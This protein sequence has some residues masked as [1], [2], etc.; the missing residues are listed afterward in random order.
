MKKNVFFAAFVGVLL[1]MQAA[2]FAAS[3]ACISVSAN[4][5]RGSRVSDVRTLQE[6]LVSRNYPGGG[7]WMITGYFGAATE[8]AVRNFQRESGLAVTGAVDSATRD[9]IVRASCGGTTASTPATPWY[10][11][12]FNYVSGWTPSAPTYPSYPTYPTYPL[13]G[14]QTPFL[15]SMSVNTGGPGTVVTIWGRNFDG[16]NNTVYFGTTPIPGVSS[17]GTSITFTVPSYTA[18]GIVQVK[19]GNSHGMS[20]GLTFNMTTQYYYP[21]TPY[22]P[23]QQYGCTYPY[24]SYCTGPTWGGVPTITYLSPSSGAVGDTV[25]VYGSGFSQTGNSVRFGNGIIAGIG[26]ADGRAVTFTVP[27]TISGYGSQSIALTTYNVSVTNAQ[28]HT[29]NS[30]PF[31]VTSLGSMGQPT[32]TNV[33]GPTTLASGTLG[34]WSLTA[35]NPGGGYLSVSVDWG[36]QGTYAASQQAAQAIYNYQQTVSFTHTYYQPGTYTIRFTVTNQSGQTNTTTITVNVTGTQQGAV[37]LSGISPSAARVGTQVVLTGT[38]FTQ[39][40]TVHFGIGGTQ[41]LPSYNGTT[42][43]YTIPSYIS[44]CDT[45]TAGMYCAAYVQLVQPGAYQVYVTN[46]NGTTQQLTFTV[47]Q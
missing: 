1:I 12:L 24:Q 43:Y 31:A 9:A 33:T 35:N 6:F 18:S 41:H 11:Q 21:Y 27:T 13:Y 19:V 38:G 47:T 42:I 46:G 8:A 30:L 36:D 37:S 15:D 32:I 25:T 20:N 44:P 23:Y 40:N 5:S 16:A 26:S 45:L 28:G 3:A 17:G 29:S 22:Q 2:P 39:D 14:M 34:T 7:S 4:L 10:Q